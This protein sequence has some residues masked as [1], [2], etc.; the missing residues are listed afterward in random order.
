ML[1]APFDLSKLSDAVKYDVVNKTEYD[2]LVQN[3]NAIDTSRFVK[4]KKIDYDYKINEINA[5]YVL[6]LAYLLLLILITL[7]IKYPALLI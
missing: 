1:P 5:K 4:K 7:K 6:L 3:G 2:V